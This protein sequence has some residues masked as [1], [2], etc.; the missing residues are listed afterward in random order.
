MPAIFVNYPYQGANTWSRTDS[1]KHNHFIDLLAGANWQAWRLRHYDSYSSRYHW[2]NYRTTLSRDIHAIHS[3]LSLG[4]NYTFS[5][6]FERFQFRG[7]QLQSDD[8]MLP[9]ST[10]GY[11]PEIH[12]IAEFY[13]TVTVLQNNILI[14]QTHVPPGPFIIDD[15]LPYY[16]ND[17]RKI[18]INEVI[19]DNE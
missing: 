2:Q 6:L 17:I 9:D 7:L 19:V 1:D 12:A 18:I 13:A 8:S 11:A 16:Y 5:S 15:L 10:Q 4:E 14:Y 3:Q